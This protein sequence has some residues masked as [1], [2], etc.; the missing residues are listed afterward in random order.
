MGGADTFRAPAAA[1]DRFVGRYSTQLARALADFAA[2]GPGTRALDVGCG[3]GALTAVLA[4]RLGAAS[5]AAVD[6][7]EPFAA[8]CRARVPG[9]GVI[10][11]RAETLPFGDGEFDVT[12]SQLVV[13]FMSDPEAGV[14]EMARVTRPGGVVAACVWDYAGEMTLLRAFWDAAREVAP[15]RGAAA[16]EG[17]VMRW[18]RDGELAE[19]WRGC[20]LEDVRPGALMVEAEYEG[21]DDLWAPLP[22]GIGPAGAFCASLDDRGRAALHEAYRC[23]LGVGDEPFRLSARAWAAAGTVAG[24]TA[25][26]MPQENTDVVRQAWDHWIRG[27]LPALFAGYDSEVVWDTSHFRDWPE[28]AYH[29]VEGVQRFLTEWLDVWDQY[30][31]DV[32]Q[33]VAAPDGRVVSLITQRGVGRDSGLPMQLEMAQV[34]TVRDGKVT[35][36]DNYDDRGEALEAVGLR[37]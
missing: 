27:D 30:E 29:G 11:A 18:C 26:A 33:I 1:Y 37:E 21:F 12:L 20:G 35:R 19:L 10:V 6:P 28:S 16:D 8:A 13:N 4:E 3:P 9:A 15:E 24:D 2:V 25:R 17:V 34:T 32:E 22:T 14:R 31:I 5:V 7:S 36:I 23:R